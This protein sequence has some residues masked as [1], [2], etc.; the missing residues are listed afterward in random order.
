MPFINDVN[1]IDKK[2]IDKSFWGEIWKEI[3]RLWKIFMEVQK[4][5]YERIK[6]KEDLRIMRERNQEENNVTITIETWWIG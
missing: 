6:H 3:M 2:S 1:D 5:E 4:K